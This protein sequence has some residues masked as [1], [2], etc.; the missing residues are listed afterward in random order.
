MQAAKMGALRHDAINCPGTDDEFSVLPTLAFLM[1]YAPG[2]R[3]KAR[4]YWRSDVSVAN[5]T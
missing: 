5:Y 3:L 1:E 4:E 2:A